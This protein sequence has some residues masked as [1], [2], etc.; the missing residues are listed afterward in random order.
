MS[1]KE[2]I[3]NKIGTAIQSSLT[4]EEATLKVGNFTG[5]IADKAGFK[6]KKVGDANPGADVILTGD[7]KAIIA[8][9][10]KY[11]G[12]E[13]GQ[14]LSSIQSDLT[15]GPG[16]K[17]EN[18]EKAKTEDSDEDSD[19]EI[20]SEIIGKKCECCDNEITD[21]GC[22]CDESCK[23]CGGMGKPVGDQKEAK[24]DPVG[25][26]D[27]DIDN[28]GDV[29]DSDDYLKNRRKKIGKAIDSKK[30]KEMA[31]ASKS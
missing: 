22:G 23:H 4:L 7:E 18:A 29:D 10:R 13:E 8:Y 9:A 24:M 20:D 11:L 30:L 26:A 14:S 3:E 27:A 31:K 2:L 16:S 1:F 15:G 6:M 19:A 25:K 17:F 12:A 21:E 5:K 28:D